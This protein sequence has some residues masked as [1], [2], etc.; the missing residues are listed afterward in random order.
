[1]T[2][3][4][5]GLFADVWEQIGGAWE[6]THRF[7]TG[8]EFDRLSDVTRDAKHSRIHLPVASIRSLQLLQKALC[9]P[10]AVALD[11]T[12]KMQDRQKEGCSPLLDALLDQVRDSLSPAQVAQVEALLKTRETGLKPVN[13][14]PPGPPL[15]GNT[16]E[17]DAESI[18][19]EAFMERAPGMEGM[20]VT[21]CLLPDLDVSKSPLVAFA[22]LENLPVEGASGTVRYAFLVVA[23]S[24]TGDSARLGDQVARSFATAMMDEDFYREV[25][26]CKDEKQLHEAFDV[27]LGSLTAHGLPRKAQ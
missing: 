6:V 22:R 15:I 3:S 5:C 25:R 1:M 17:S 12:L 4:T 24:E 13:K 16:E 21:V 8:L 19:S 20:D 14:L 27:Y 2:K 18:S 9:R 7:N 10:K 11:L 26:V 23:S